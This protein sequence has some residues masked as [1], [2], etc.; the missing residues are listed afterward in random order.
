VVVND[1]IGP[2][3][4]SE[5]RDALAGAK[6]FLAGLL[7]DGPLSSKQVRS[8]ADGAGYSWRT[9]RRAQKTLNVVAIKEGQPGDKKQRWVWRMPSKVATEDV[10]QNS[11]ATFGESRTSKGFNHAG[12]VEDGQVPLTGHLRGD[13]GHLRSDREG[14][15]I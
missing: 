3:S 14:I 13:D 8:D 7:A 15:E 12:S 10:H 1:V 9:I 4:D 11:L 6:D 2:Q 5:D